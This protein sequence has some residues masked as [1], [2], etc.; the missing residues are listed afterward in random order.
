MALWFLVLTQRA[1][2][3]KQHCTT[4]T[5]EMETVNFIFFCLFLHGASAATLKTLLNLVQVYLYNQKHNSDNFHWKV[6]VSVALLYKH[7]IHSVTKGNKPNFKKRLPLRVTGKNEA[8]T[9]IHLYMILTWH[10]PSH[11]M[12]HWA[13]MSSQMA[14]LWDASHLVE[15]AFVTCTMTAVCR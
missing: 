1:I 8:V 10:T 14:R 5:K 3:W 2:H 12:K 15:G 11:T 7:I 6:T 4:T 13:G 9:A